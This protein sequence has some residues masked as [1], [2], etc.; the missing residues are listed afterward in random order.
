MSVQ[1]SSPAARRLL[2]LAGTT[3]A[4]DLTRAA[5]AAGHHVTASFAGRTSQPSSP[6]TD[7]RIGGF[8][9][10]DGL[11]AYLRDNPFDAVVL[12]THPFAARMPY[13][14]AAAAEATGTPLV[15]ILRPQWVP[16]PGD[17]WTM[18]PDLAAAAWALHES[19][20]RRVLLTTGR[21]ELA[22][23]ARLDRVHFVVRSIEEPDV[24]AFA[25]ADVILD[26]GPFDAEAE[27]ELLRSRRIDTIVTKNSG[28]TATA[29]KLE[30]AYN[31]NVRVIMVERPD[32]PAVTTVATATAAMK[33]LATLP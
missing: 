2:V 18:V 5:L 24:G 17:R 6:A 30:A 12:A 13:N 19:H 15:R 25:D 3:E 26:R 29:A 16:E 22:P 28:G 31:E 7:I 33:W 9:G 14:A 8:G 21:Q 10:A 27:A 20:A 32:S 1:S 11:T 4:T 23:F